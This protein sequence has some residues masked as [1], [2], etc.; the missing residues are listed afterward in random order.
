MKKLFTLFF[1]LS[2]VLMNSAQAQE[3]F[4]MYPGTEWPKSNATFGATFRNDGGSQKVMFAESAAE[5]GLFELE[6]PAGEWI[7]ILFTRYDPTGQYVWQDFSS[8][9]PYDR[10]SNCVTVIGWASSYALSSYPP[11]PVRIK[12]KNTMGWNNVN[13][14]AWSPAGNVFAIW[15]GATMSPE[16]NNWHSFQIDF[17]KGFGAHV[18]NFADG[19]EYQELLLKGENILTSTCFEKL[20]AATEASV[21]ACPVPEILKSSISIG[22]TSAPAN[23]YNAKSTEHTANLQGANLGTFVNADALKLGGSMT[24][25]SMMDIEA[26]LH[27]MI[28]NNPALS[29]TLSLSEVST[30]LLNGNVFQIAN[31]DILSSL[32]LADGDYTIAIWFTSAV[33]DIADTDNN[34]G[35]KYVASFKL[36]ANTTGI[37]SSEFVKSVTVENGQIVALFDGSSQVELFTSVG[38]LQFAGTAVDRFA[39]PAQQGVYIIRINGEPFKLLVP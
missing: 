16:A 8:A 33:D 30:S 6:I 27:Y 7:D 26:E 37:N 21:C 2:A 3:K 5:A 39:Y 17:H 14:Y 38:Q 20:P 19:G 15:P 9:V 12:F 4:Y 32:S 18:S 11:K 25:T 28:N 31:E 1:I 24:I 13:T 10:K 23:W 29:G 22:E 36:D 34:S 35:A